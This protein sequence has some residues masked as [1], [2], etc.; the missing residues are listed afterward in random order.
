VQPARRYRTIIQVG[1][2]TPSPPPTPVPDELRD[3]LE[4]IS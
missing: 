1:Y 2:N 3:A 4:A